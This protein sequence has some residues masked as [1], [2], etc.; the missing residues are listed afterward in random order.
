M[1]LLMVERGRNVPRLGRRLS[2][3]P[4]TPAPEA[5]RRS[6]VSFTE[7]LR[8]RVAAGHV[9]R[10]RV[11]RESDRANNDRRGHRCRNDRGEA[12]VVTPGGV[13]SNDVPE[14]FWSG[15]H[16]SSCGCGFTS[17]GKGPCGGQQPPS[18]NR[19][20]GALRS[21]QV[22]GCIP[23]NRTRGGAAPSA[24]C[25]DGSA[26]WEREIDIG[27]NP[28]TGEAFA[29]IDFVNVPCVMG[30]RVTYKGSRTIA[31]ALMGPADMTWQ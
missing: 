16:H 7:L 28:K 19:R 9:D 31:P 8:T 2:T 15:G 3:R 12:W 21:V 10:C 18:G 4:S 24:R 1:S 29:G 30:W 22:E 17:V 5:P 6:H 14:R 26:R 13:L 25:T 11:R 23:D 20:V 27:L